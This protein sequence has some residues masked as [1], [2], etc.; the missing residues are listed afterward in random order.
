MHATPCYNSDFTITEAGSPFR[1]VCLQKERRAVCEGINS[2]FLKPAGAL[3]AC[4]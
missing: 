3:D 2:F 4:F 1:N